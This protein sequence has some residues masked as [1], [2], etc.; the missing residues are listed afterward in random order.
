MMYS[1]EIARYSKCLFV[2]L[3]VFTYTSSFY[4]YNSPVKQLLLFHTLYPFPTSSGVTRLSSHGVRAEARARQTAQVARRH[5]L[6]QSHKAGPWH[7]VLWAS[8]L[9]EC[10]LLSDQSVGKCGCENGCWTHGAV[11]PDLASGRNDITRHRNSD[12]L[13]WAA[14]FLFF[15]ERHS[16]QRLL[17]KLRL[18]KCLLSGSKA[19]FPMWLALTIRDN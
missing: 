6:P 16:Q 11:T 17:D 9:A 13:P 12:S 4:H 18:Q 1:G 10:P 2:H 5:S 19:E 3:F 15:I 7:S 14:E 8:A